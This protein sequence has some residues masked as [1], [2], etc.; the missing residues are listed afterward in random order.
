MQISLVVNEASLHHAYEVISTLRRSSFFSGVCVL[1]IRFIHSKVL[2]MIVML[3]LD[4]L[5][6]LLVSQ[7]SQTCS[8]II[9]HFL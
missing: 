3:C 1:R 4:V 9:F 8:R 2:F 6:R 7:V 5:G